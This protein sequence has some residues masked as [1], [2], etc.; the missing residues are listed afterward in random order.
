MQALYCGDE[1]APLV[2]GTCCHCGAAIP[3][4]ML[5]EEHREGELL[6]FCCRGCRGAYLLITGAGLGDFYRR[7]EWREPGLG[8]EAFASA[9]HDSALARFVAAAGSGAPSTSSSKV[10][11]APPVSGSTRK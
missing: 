3:I 1:G 7:R 10:F 8:D 9:Y 4:G 6:A 2:N 5:V 11:V